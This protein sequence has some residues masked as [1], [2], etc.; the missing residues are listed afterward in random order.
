MYKRL[1]FHVKKP[2]EETI[3]IKFITTLF[4][5]DLSDEFRQ[6]LR[7][8]VNIGGKG[9]HNPRDTAIT[10]Y[11]A[12]RKVCDRHIQL[13]LDQQQECPEDMP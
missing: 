7:L 12:S 4:G 10:N 3:R 9:T 6:V 8:P 5:C 11:A 1:L 13:Q 2:L